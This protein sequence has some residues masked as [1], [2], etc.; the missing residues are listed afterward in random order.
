MNDSVTT[1]DDE[2]VRGGRGQAGAGLRGPNPQCAG[3][4]C[5]QGRKQRGAGWRAGGRRESEQLPGVCAYISHHVCAP[6]GLPL[7][8][9]TRSQQ[10]HGRHVRRERTGRER[11]DAWLCYK[12]G[13]YNCAPAHTIGRHKAE[14]GRR[15]T[16]PAHVYV[17]VSR[18]QVAAQ[19][20]EFLLRLHIRRMKA[21]LAAELKEEEKAAAAAGAEQAGTGAAAAGLA[22]TGPTPSGG[23]FGAG[24]ARSGGSFG[25]G[26]AGQGSAA[27][28]A[29][30]QGVTGAAH[31]VPPRTGGFTAPPPGGG[32]GTS[33][34][35]SRS[36]SRNTSTSGTGGKSSSGRVAVQ[37]VTLGM[38][39]LGLSR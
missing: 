5:K 16:T 14:K 25:A 21:Q 34:V 38:D 39:G 13:M 24:P 32:G 37:A 29:H 2:P 35:G 19:H 31:R 20:R 36:L 22:A 18:L 8:P 1:V 27:S 33:G 10:G 4:R 28:A 6:H 11:T 12:E 7:T 15:H 30:G 26:P 23:S 9:P 3:L 17:A